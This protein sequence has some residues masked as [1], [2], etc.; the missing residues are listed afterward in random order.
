MAVH[1]APKT[2]RVVEP[3]PFGDVTI[4][5]SEVTGRS[6]AQLA[7]DMAARL[8]EANPASNADALRHLRTAFPDSPL[9]VRVAAIAAMMRR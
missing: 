1:A 5:P 9:T 2:L 8:M 6:E 4:A 7:R 3:D